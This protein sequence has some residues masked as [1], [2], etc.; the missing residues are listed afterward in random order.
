M[1]VAIA[2]NRN[3]ANGDLHLS[4]ILTYHVVA[5]KIDAAAAIAADGTEV[6]TV[7]GDTIE[8]SVV[9]AT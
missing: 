5:G 9:T 8:V 4:G 3:S 2:R 7:N 6:A 1:I